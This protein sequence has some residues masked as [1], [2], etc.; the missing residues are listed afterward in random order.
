MDDV[1]IATVAA[2]SA[3]ALFAVATALQHRSAGLVTEADRDKT[4]RVAGFVSR[5]VRHPLW[6]FG[7]LA[8]LGGL[9]LHALALRDGPLTLVQP[10]LVTGVVFALP[11]RR[12]LEH[13]RP[14]RDE[15]G[16]TA[17]LAI[18]LV[19]FL[20]L[21]SPSGGA[22]HSPDPIPAALSM[23]AIG[24]GVA[25]SSSLGRRTT[26]ATA[27]LTL[28]VATGLM[29]AATAALLKELMTLLN[30]GIG[31]LFTAWA[32][33]ALLLVGAVGMVL[34]QLAYQAGPLRFS[35]PVITT[36]DPIASLV[37]GIAVFDEPFRSGSLYLV[38]EALGLVLILAAAVALTRF[39]STAGGGSAD[40]YASRRR[41][42]TTA[43]TKPRTTHPIST[44][45]PH[46]GVRL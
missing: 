25:A 11:L 16:W 12:L 8:D 27:A 32:F 40:G 20:A 45:S 21:S 33:Y 23:A 43:T 15:L 10:L 26:G 39:E 2:L 24:L 17:V 44:A 37:I 34:N 18:G 1:L 41:S 19:L 3:A 31:S 4:A 5:T 28:G 38:G 14:R 22:G 46:Q 35:L 9:G 13:R 7:T 30:G 29:F 6:L 42:N 36:V